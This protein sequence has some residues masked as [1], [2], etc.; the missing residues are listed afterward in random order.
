MFKNLGCPNF[1]TYSHAYIE[2]IE[3]GACWTVRQL[4]PRIVCG[5]LRMKSFPGELSFFKT[6]ALVGHFHCYLHSVY[7]HAKVEPALSM[8]ALACVS[9]FLVWYWLQIFS[10]HHLKQVD[11]QLSQDESSN[12]VYD[13]PVVLVP[14]DD[15]SSTEGASSCQNAVAS[16]TLSIEILRDGRLT[17]DSLTI[18]FSPLSLFLEDTLLYRLVATTILELCDLLRQRKFT[19]LLDYCIFMPQANLLHQE[20]VFLL[21]LNGYRPHESSGSKV[22]PHTIQCL[23]SCHLQSNEGFGIISVPLLYT[24]IKR[25]VSHFLYQ[26]CQLG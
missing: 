14:R 21:A 5:W 1:R 26:C 17:A 6:V 11:N 23:W 8:D 7:I 16:L 3:C 18:K 10:L 9:A 24:D 2:E 19:K 25:M 15:T 12:E 22:P 20:L 13:F 4:I